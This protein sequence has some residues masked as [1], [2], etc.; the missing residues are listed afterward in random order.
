MYIFILTFFAGCGIMV[1]K[2]VLLL[3]KMLKDLL[4]TVSLTKMLELV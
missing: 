2:E 1:K 4:R 3:L